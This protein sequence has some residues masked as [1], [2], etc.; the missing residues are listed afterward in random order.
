MYNGSQAFVMTQEEDLGCGGQMIQIQDEV[1][2][3]HEGNIDLHEQI[4]FSSFLEHSQS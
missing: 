1:S 2:Q 3:N 4:S